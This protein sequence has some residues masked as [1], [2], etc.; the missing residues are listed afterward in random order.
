MKQRIRNF[1]KKLKDS[2]KYLNSCEKFLE[3]LYRS[4]IEH[5]KLSIELVFNH[6][7]MSQTYSNYSFDKQFTT[8]IFLTCLSQIVISSVNYLT[9]DNSVNFWDQPGSLMIEK[10]NQS[11]ALKDHIFKCYNKMLNKRN[12]E[13]CDKFQ[14]LFVIAFE[15]Y[16]MFINRL[17]TVSDHEI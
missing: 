5:L 7:S 17:E 2:V 12:A 6:V 9:N 15:N 16:V 3:E 1:Y 8:E 4:D 10:L 11:I 14:I 13:D